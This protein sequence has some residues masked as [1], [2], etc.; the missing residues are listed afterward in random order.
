M[1]KEGTGVKDRGYR[2]GRP[3][4]IE[5]IGAGTGRVEEGSRGA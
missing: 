3:R 5:R 4:K 2:T 1:E